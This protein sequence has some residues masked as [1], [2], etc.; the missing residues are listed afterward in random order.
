MCYYFVARVA[1][2]PLII[3]MNE[4]N[5]EIEKETSLT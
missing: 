3:M 2:V 4:P 1:A 5:E